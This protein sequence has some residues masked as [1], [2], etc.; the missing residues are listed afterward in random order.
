VDCLDYLLGAVA[1]GLR[2]DVLYHQAAQKHRNGKQQ[3]I[4]PVAPGIY[5]AV[6]KAL[7]KRGSGNA[8]YYAGE[9]RQ[10]EPLD[11][12]NEED[13]FLEYPLYHLTSRRKSFM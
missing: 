3:K 6:L 2:C 8:D 10:E 9:A 1:L 11:D 4:E 12:A 5:G 7:E 13:G